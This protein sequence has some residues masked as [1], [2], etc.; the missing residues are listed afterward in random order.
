VR[1]VL[2]LDPLVTAGVGAKQVLIVAIKVVVAFVVMLIAVIF[3]VWF[4]RK[5]IAGFQNRIGPNKAGRWGILQTIADGLK[6]VTKE[7]IH[8]ERSDRMVFLLAPYL[9]VVPVFV[10]FSIVPLGGDFSNGNNGVVS[11]LGEKTLLQVA[12]PPIGILL[13][14]AMS[15]ISVYGAMLAGWSSGSKYPLLGSVRASAQMVS[16]EAGLGLS[17]ATVLVVCGT[18]STNGIVVAQDGIRNWNIIATGVVP[19][20]VFFLAITAEMN[21]PPFDLTEAEQELVGGYQTEYSSMRFAMYYL[22]EFLAVV[23]MSTIIITLFLGGP[24]G[25][26]DIPGIPNALEG[27]LWLLAK[28]FV[29]LFIY[30]WLRATL[31]RFR[32]DQ[33]MDLGWKLLIPVAFGWLLLITALKVAQDEDWNRVVVVAIALAVAVVAWVIFTVALRASARNRELEGSQY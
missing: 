1:Y 17:I 3:M 11:I 30:V 15:A 10:T 21:R 4:E 19:F 2:A 23:V 5:L 20:I 13:M 31:P 6:L 28:L 26:F 14:L 27:T 8:P 33:L 29:F 22:A 25:L 32:Y 18:L 9:A 12:D 16:Y 24:R 7:Y